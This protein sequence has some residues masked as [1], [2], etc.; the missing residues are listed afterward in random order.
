MSVWVWRLLPSSSPKPMKSGTSIAKPKT[1]KLNSSCGGMPELLTKWYWMALTPEAS[2][3]FT[4]NRLGGRGGGSG[5]PIPA[6][7]WPAHAVIV[8]A[9]RCSPSL[10]FCSRSFFLL[11]GRVAVAAAPPTFICNDGLSNFCARIFPFYFSRLCKMSVLFGKSVKIC[12][13][14]VPVFS[15]GIPAKSEDN[16]ITSIGYR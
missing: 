7:A 1:E 3:S 15:G 8:M 9:S 14:S 13:G 6:K 5:S 10:P 12:D 2:L 16:Q 4:S 11:L